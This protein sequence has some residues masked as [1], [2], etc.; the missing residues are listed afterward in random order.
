MSVQ[1]RALWLRSYP[2]DDF[3]PDYTVLLLEADIVEGGVAEHRPVL[4][5]RY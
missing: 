5:V 3:I 4:L 1:S 2:T